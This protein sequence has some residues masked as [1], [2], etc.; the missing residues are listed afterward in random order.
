MWL[1]LNNIGHLDAANDIIY[2]CI[3]IQANGQPSSLNGIPQFDMVLRI[4]GKQGDQIQQIRCCVTV[5]L[6][7]DVR[8]IKVYIDG[9]LGSRCATPSFPFPPLADQEKPAETYYPDSQCCSLIALHY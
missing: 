8:G 2:T 9:T 1:D 3:N 7:F 6:M 5:P 4:I